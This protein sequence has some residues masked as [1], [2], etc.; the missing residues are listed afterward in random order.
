[1]RKTMIYNYKDSVVLDESTPLRSA[2]DIR[3][4]IARSFDAELDELVLSFEATWDET[5]TDLW[6]VREDLQEIETTLRSH[7]ISYTVD[8]AKLR[9]VDRSELFE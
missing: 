3:D 9:R 7:E 5:S 4:E 2:L 1:M 8:R 6:T